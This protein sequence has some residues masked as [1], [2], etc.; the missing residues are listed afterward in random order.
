MY[1]GARRALRK[2]VLLRLDAASITGEETALLER[3]SQV[4]VEHFQRPGYPEAERI[5]LARGTAP[6]ELGVD[7][8]A[9]LQ[10]N[11]PKRL[12]HAHPH[13]HGREV[14]LESFAI[15]V[16]TGL[17]FHD[18]NLGT[19]PLTTSGGTGEDL[20][21]YFSTFAMLNSRGW[22]FC[23]LCACSGPA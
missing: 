23:E 3:I 22:G 19:G 13:R 17:A 14:L 20:R 2:A 11:R 6:F 21:H 15:Q 8:V 4:G 9:A 16:E 5:D 12:E 18:A 7:G 1:C 10:F